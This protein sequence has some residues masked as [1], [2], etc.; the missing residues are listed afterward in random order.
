MLRFFARENEHEISI[1]ANN[2]FSES[3]MTWD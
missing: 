3:Q 1:G 2:D